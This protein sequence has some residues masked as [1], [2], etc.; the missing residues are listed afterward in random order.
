MAVSKGRSPRP[1]D[2]FSAEIPCYRGINREFR[3]INREFVLFRAQSDA[4]IGPRRPGIRGFSG[5]IP[6]VKTGNMNRKNREYETQEQGIR[7]RGTGNTKTRN[8]E[9]KKVRNGECVALQPEMHRSVERTTVRAAGAAG[10]SGESARFDPPPMGTLSPLS[11]AKTATD[12]K[13]VLSLSK[14][15][16]SAPLAIPPSTTQPLIATFEKA[17]TTSSVATSWRL[18]VSQLGADAGRKA[19]MDRARAETQ[20]TQRTVGLN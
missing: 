18:C 19:S 2:D 3:E 6:I 11:H 9:F 1:E 14:G 7:F 20:R 12:A 16:P 8:R 4:R 17:G 10:N 15:C 13:P 5:K